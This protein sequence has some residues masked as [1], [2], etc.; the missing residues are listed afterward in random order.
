[1]SR[2]LVSKI[3]LLMTVLAAVTVTARADEPKLTGRTLGSH[4]RSVLW[5]T[6]TN[7]GKT[8]VSSSRDATIKVWDV[9]TGEVKKTLTNH[10]ADVYC[11][12]FSHDGNLM[13]SGS[14]DT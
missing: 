8:L 10:K 1:M 5:V 7:D 6:Y 4:K 2:L 14:T 12:T 9:A 11:V 13:A 3:A